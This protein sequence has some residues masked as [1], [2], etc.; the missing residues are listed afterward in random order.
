MSINGIFNAT[1]CFIGI[2]ILLIHVF[3]LL[4]KKERRKDENNLLIFL[5]FT[6]I[7]FVTYLTFTFVKVKYTSD[8]FIISFYTTFYIFNNIEVFLLFL[9]MLSYVSFK[10]KNKKTLYIINH[11]IFLLF[12]ALDIVNIFT[13]LF[14]TSSG[15]E[16]KRSNL[17]IIAQGYEFIMFFIIFL[18]VVLNKKLVFREKI[19]FTIYVLLP[20]V[21]ILLQT[22]FKGYA[23]GYLSIIIAIEIL[24]FFLNVKKNMQLLEEQEKNKD[25]QIRVMMSQIQPHFVYNSLSSISTLI[26]I[27]P[28]KAQKALD[29]FTEYLRHNLSSLTETSLIHFEDELKHIKVYLSLEELRFNDRIKINYDIRSSEFMVPPLSIQ[30][31]VENAV[32]HGILKKVE[33]G[34]LTIKSYS[35]DNAK[36]V[37]IIDDGVGFDLSKID[38]NTNE[39]F[40]IENIRSRLKIMCNGKLEI[41]SKPGQGAKSII[42]FYK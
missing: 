16:Y 23:I 15:G 41:I 34:T 18:V 36:I 3:N 10:E 12:I 40:G 21:A 5:V 6:V 28:D 14:F 37:E 35:K 27:N 24:F 31:L 20:L 4:F 25:A 26:P 22:I 13:G 2:G 38:F 42:T 30:P 29:N 9:Y 19:A 7:H 32:K 17:M 1:V 33:G 8:T 39:H 11:L